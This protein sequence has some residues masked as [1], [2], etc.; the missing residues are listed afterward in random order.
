MQRVALTSQLE[1]QLKTATIED[2]VVYSAGGI[3]YDAVAS[4]AA[5]RLANTQN[6]LHNGEWSE[7]LESRGVGLNQLTQEPIIGEVR[8]YLTNRTRRKG[9][10][11]WR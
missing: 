8:S 10:E 1:S 3:W 11:E 2:Y 4:L 9:R 7:L 6:V 5:L